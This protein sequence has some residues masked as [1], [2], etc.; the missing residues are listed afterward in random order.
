MQEHY[1]QVMT[2]TATQEDAERIAQALV[3]RREAAC[4]QI[5][6]PIRSIYRW[7]G[8]VETSQEWLCLV[9]SRQDLF[10]R[11]EATIRSLHP[12]EVP[13]ILA[14]PVMAGSAGYLAWLD[15][16]IKAPGN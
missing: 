12:Y 6:G 5:I 7:Q 1:I 4:V 15:Q 3:Q 10:P 14:V 16:E 8:N 9:K 11:I 13:E 2:T